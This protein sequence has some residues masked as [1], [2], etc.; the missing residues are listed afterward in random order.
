MTQIQHHCW[1]SILNSAVVNTQKAIEAVTTEDASRCYKS[2]ILSSCSLFDFMKAGRWMEQRFSS[3]S[4]WQD[5]RA[6]SR[7]KAMQPLRWVMARPRILSEF[8]VQLWSKATIRNQMLDL[9]VGVVLFHSWS[10]T[11]GEGGDADWSVRISLTLFTPAVNLT[12]T[13]SMALPEIAPCIDIIRLNT[14][15]KD[16]TYFKNSN[17]IFKSGVHSILWLVFTSSSQMWYRFLNPDNLVPLVFSA[18]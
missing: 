9:P 7:L 3:S 15:K 17:F 16:Y 1:R 6:A 11:R 18:H 2:K 5:T 14:I 4:S 8:S 12:S 10:G 13:I